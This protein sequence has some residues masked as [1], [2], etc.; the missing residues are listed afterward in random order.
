M[1]EDQWSQV[2]NGDVEAQNEC[3][4]STPGTIPE[5]RKAVTYDYGDRTL[6]SMQPY[7]KHM[8]GSLEMII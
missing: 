2:S 5:E 7:T 6:P 8:A 3:Q 1:Y 4:G